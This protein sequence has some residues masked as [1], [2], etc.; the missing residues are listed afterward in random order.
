M[1]APETERRRHPL[2]LLLLYGLGEM[3]ITMLMALIGLFALFFYNSV[4]KLPAVVVGGGI[5][6][7]LVLD[8]LLDPYIG[9]R[10]DRSRHPLG[11]RHAFMLPG[12]LLTGPFFFLFFSPPRGLSRTWLFVWLLL[13]SMAMRAASAV[14]RI[15]YLSIGAELT[16]DYD[17]RTRVMGIRALFALLGLIAA[18]RFSF[19]FFP[20]LPG[21]LDSKTAYA[22]Y[23]R[24][25]LVFGAA[26]S[27]AALLSL[28]GTL[29]CRTF[30]AEAG[31]ASPARDFFAGFRIAMRNPAFRCVWFSFT[32]FFLAL[33]LNAS[34]AIHFFK[35]QAR[36]ASND[37][38]GVIMASLYVGAL[39]GVFLWMALAKKAEKR[40]LFMSASIGLTAMLGSAALLIGPG[41]LFGTGR[42]AP[43]IAGYA[44]GGILASALW[45]I[46]PSMVAD[47]AD[48]D[49][50]LTGLRREGIY[51]GIVSFGEKIAA[52]GALLLAG[53]LLSLF[54]TSH[55]A[56]LYSVA[57]TALL[58]AAI[59]LIRPYRLTR[60][61]LREIQVMLGGITVEVHA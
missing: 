23:P 34:L 44:L 16:Q 10:S 41:L 58:I 8:A 38:I 14:Y 12:A 21:G 36:I 48:S 4:M 53:I 35:E 32:L 24:L 28:L 17:E 25:G 19:L 56:L 31:P 27:V 51:F 43:L 61:R 15:P 50:L 42:P 57:P 1:P 39:P 45:V 54:G 46:P 5:A 40:T 29:R 30:G 60:A 37:T 9:Y 59:L 26:M 20:A 18:S 47:I 49:E 7:G 11:R 6:A 13:C 3:P 52:G 33:T 2:G 55:V 22:G